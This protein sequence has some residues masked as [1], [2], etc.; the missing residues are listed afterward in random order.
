MSGHH[1]FTLKSEV[2]AKLAYICKQHFKIGLYILL[3][4]GALPFFLVA[5]QALIKVC[6]PGAAEGTISSIERVQGERIY[7]CF[8]LGLWQGIS[9]P[10]DLGTGTSG[11]RC[12][13]FLSVAL[14]LNKALVH[15]IRVEKYLPGF[16]LYVLPL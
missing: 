12:A 3:H 10:Q 1:F 9:S 14:H 13:L 5:P 6:F 15:S 7:C 4:D 11:A 8:L 2:C 16:A